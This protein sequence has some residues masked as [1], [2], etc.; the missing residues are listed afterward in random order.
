MTFLKK[1]LKAQKKKKGTI[2]LHDLRTKKQIRNL[3]LH[4]DSINSVQFSPDSNRI[5]SCSNDGHLRVTEIGGSEL[6][7]AD[8]KNPLKFRFIF[9]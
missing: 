1:K 7:T 2:V 6:L 8:L 5:L 4:L 9:V 3:P